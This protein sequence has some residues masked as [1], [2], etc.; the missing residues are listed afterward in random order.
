[1]NRC[2]P[3]RSGKAGVSPVPAAQFT[4]GVVSLTQVQLIALIQQAKSE[5][6]ASKMLADGGH[7]L[8][9]GIQYQF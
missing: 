9:S 3:E 4:S 1:M 7:C 5:W 2:P 6:Q 8:S